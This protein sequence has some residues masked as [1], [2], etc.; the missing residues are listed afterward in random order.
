MIISFYPNT[1][2]VFLFIYVDNVNWQTYFT[3]F[4]P[5]PSQNSP[6]YIYVSTDRMLYITR[7]F[8]LNL[9]HPSGLLPAEKLYCPMCIFSFTRSLYARKLVDFLNLL[10]FFWIFYAL[11]FLLNCTSKSQI[12]FLKFI[13]N[14]L[15]WQGRD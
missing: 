13:F 9:G 10:V 5:V 14:Y 15:L 6:I 3:S 4:F 12:F 7:S 11:M 8:H 1:I 2:L